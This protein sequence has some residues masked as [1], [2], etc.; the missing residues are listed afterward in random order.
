MTIW[1][2]VKKYKTEGSSLNLNKESSGRGRTEQSHVNINLFQ[3]NLIADARISDRKN[4]LEISKSTS[5]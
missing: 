5:L 2:N 4:G 1:K 3:E